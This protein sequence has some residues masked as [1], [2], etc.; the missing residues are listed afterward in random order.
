M[1]VLRRASS[2]WTSEYFPKG[3][4]FLLIV[5]LKRNGVCGMQAN[6]C[7]SSATSELRAFSPLRKYLESTEG[8]TS[9]R[10]P[11]TTEDFPEPVLPMRAIFSPG[12]ASIEILLRAKV[13]S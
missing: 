1:Q 10:S 9:R 11:C 13:F 6:C 4:R 12:L 2:I 3:S 5:S 7:L 8:S